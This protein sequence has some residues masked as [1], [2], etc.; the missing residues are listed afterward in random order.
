M[1]NKVQLREIEQM[2]NDFKPV[3]A[4]I[5]PLFL[6]NSQEYAQESAELTFKRVEAVSDLRNKHVTPKDTV[7]HQIASKL[8]S[9]TFKSYF[10]AS[11]YVQS[12]LQSREGVEQVSAQALEEHNKQYDELLLLGEGTAANNVVNNG[13]YWSGDSNYVLESSTEIDNEDCVDLHTSVMANVQDADQLEGRKV[14]LF[15]GEGLLPIFD[16]VYASAPTPFKKVLA[17]VLGPNYSL[18]KLPAAITP[19]SA[20]GWIIVNL[21]AVKMHYSGAPKILSQGVNDEKMYVWQNF[22]M[23]SNMLDV[24]SSGGII[25]Q[26][27]TIEA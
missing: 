5:Y 13:L 8:G 2:M 9:K 21:D 23:G 17:E 16:S 15:Y 20:N 25:R 14:I 12:A 4:P 3:Y 7:L 27:V 19:A 26:P 18:A 6:G 1:T 22:L 10:Q 11:Q 24:M